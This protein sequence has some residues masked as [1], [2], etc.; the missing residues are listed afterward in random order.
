MDETVYK[1]DYKT[2]EWVISEDDWFNNADIEDI[3]FV[4]ELNCDPMAE[5]YNESV[6][7]KSAWDTLK[8][9]YI[10]YSELKEY[11]YNKV[12]YWYMN[13]KGKKFIFSENHYDF[14]ARYKVKKRTAY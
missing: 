1:Y 7:L 14:Y 9:T 2:Q 4:F 8:R 10:P 11:N 13:V 12:G 6:L 3:P 5:D